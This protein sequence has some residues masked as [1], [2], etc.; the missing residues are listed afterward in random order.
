[1]TVHALRL[2]WKRDG[3]DVELGTCFDITRPVIG[4]LISYTSEEAKDQ[5]GVWRVV[6][7][8]H[9]PFMARSDT[10]RDWTERG[11][12]PKGMT[13]YWVEPAEGPWEP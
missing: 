6:S 4:E 8:Y 9:M 11:R 10:W 2:V 1:M 7:V 12:E 13:Y 5:T 3:E